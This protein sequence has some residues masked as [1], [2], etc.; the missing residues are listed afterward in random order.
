MGLLF[1]ATELAVT[2]GTPLV[3]EAV[4]PTIFAIPAE[5]APRPVRIFIMIPAERASW[6]VRIF[7]MIPA[8]GAS[9]P[10]RV[11]VMIPAE[12]TSWPV[13][14]FTIAVPSIRAALP[15]RFVTV[16]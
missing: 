16:A 9:R 1:P 11:F 4:P 8:E 12:G 6:P 13:R 15:L 7:I 5:R 2:E 14:V 10:V 3:T